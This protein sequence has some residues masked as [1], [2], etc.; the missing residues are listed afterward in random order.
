M[1]LH[2]AWLVAHNARVEY[3]IL[4]RH[5]PG[6]SP[7]GIIDTLKLARF[8]WPNLQSYTL[9]SL[10]ARTSSRSGPGTKERHRAASDARATALLARAL[11]DESNLLSWDDV[12]RVACPAGLPGS[13]TQPSKQEDLW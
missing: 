1:A 8:V 3:D 7:V 11:T 12:R 4:L 6:W 5:L 10:M 9:E 13:F 2:D